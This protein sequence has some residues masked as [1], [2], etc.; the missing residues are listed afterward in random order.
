MFSCLSI[1][2][3]QEGQS[4]WDW[5]IMRLDLDTGTYTNLCNVV[6]VCLNACGIHPQTNLVYCNHRPGSDNLVRVDCD[7]NI[8]DMELRDQEGTLAD[9]EV[10]NGTVCYLGRIQETFA[11]NLDE[12]G[13]FWFKEDAGANNG[14]D[15]FR[16]TN[17]TLNSVETT[18]QRDPFTTGFIAG[19]GENEE[20]VGRPQLG[21]MA[22]LN[23]VTRTFPELNVGE[24]DYVVGCSSN[25]VYVQQVGGC[26][27]V[28]C[29][30][31]P[32]SAVAAEVTGDLT[33]VDPIVL[34]MRDIDPPPGQSNP[35]ASG[36]QW[37][38]NGTI[39]CAYND[40]TLR[41]AVHDGE[42]VPCP[43]VSG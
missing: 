15:L 25:R 23:V 4:F 34:T 36:A 2:P 31:G 1:L 5:Q 24:Q 10:P 21:R 19:A 27:G 35:R 7:I 9:A 8:T 29:V 13:E 41:D 38:F 16:I 20:V 43:Q 39:Y 12:N 14:G 3:V 32:P 17:N 26:V 30:L 37:L 42:S 11:A 18:G 40:G 33:N 6:G 28:K 22:D